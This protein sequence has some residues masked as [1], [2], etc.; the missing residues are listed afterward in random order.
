MIYN[1]LIPLIHKTGSKLSPKQFQEK[2]NIVFHNYEAGHYDKMHQDMWDSLQEQI[3]LLIDNLG[4]LPSKK[5]SLLD[6]GCGTGLSTQ[7]LLNSKLGTSIEKITLLDTSLNMLKQAEEKAKNWHIN[8]KIINADI[9]GIKERYDVIMI[10]SVLHHIPDLKSFLEQVDNVLNP[11]GILIHLQDPNG[12]FLNDV[13]YLGRVQEYRNYAK[14]KP[15]KKSI[16]D[17]V[18]KSIKNYLNR[19]IGRKTYIDL[20]N[21]QL[22]K[23][24]VIKKRMSADEIWSVTDIHVETKLNNEITGISFNFLRMQLINYSLINHRSYGFYGLLKSDLPDQYKIIEDDLIL[25]NELNG[26][27]ISCIWVKK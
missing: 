8:Y 11:N 6:I 27:N 22:I 21:D 7:I 18:P 4:N 19:K 10:C 5:L 2:I 24:N 15:N 1:K 3:N 9:S 23:E 16:S 14:S 20:V 13:K 26:R 25:K 17:I 12:D